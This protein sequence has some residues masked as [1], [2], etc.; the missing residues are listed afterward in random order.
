MHGAS[1]AACGASFSP[2]RARSATSHKATDVAAIRCS[3]A[4]MRALAQHNDIADVDDP[5]PWRNATP[6]GRAIVHGGGSGRRLRRCTVIG[7]AGGD[8]RGDDGGHRSM[9]ASDARRRINRCGDDLDASSRRHS[10]GSGATRRGHRPPKRCVRAQ[11]LG[12]P[13]TTRHG[14]A[15]ARQSAEKG[16]SYHRRHARAAGKGDAWRSP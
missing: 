8:G 13:A 1:T 12:G 7:A 2:R 16:V 4:G 9:T 15:P 14:K 6:Q 10:T 11:R 3:L 5:P